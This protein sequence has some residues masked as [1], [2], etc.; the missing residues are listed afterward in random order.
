MTMT[1]GR[2]QTKVLLALSVFICV[3]IAA[4]S[5]AGISSAGF[6]AAEAPG[7]QVQCTGQDLIN[8]FFIVPFFL[9][10]AILLYYG[11]KK[12]LLPWTGCLLYL[13]YTYLVYCFDVHFNEFFIDYCIILGLSFYLCIYSFLHFI[14]SNDEA[15]FGKAPYRLTGVF[16]ITV[17]IAFVFLWLSEIIPAQLQNTLPATLQEA[18]LFTNPVHVIDLSV[19]LPG[20][21]IAG[22][23]LLKRNRFSAVI[24]PVLLTFF[25]LMDITIAVL[26]FLMAQKSPESSIPVVISMILLALFSLVL[27]IFHLKARPLSQ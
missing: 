16:F 20:V 13:I 10:S 5:Y 14:K 19:F 3:L 9:V 21:F 12:S 2:K 8:L 24:A 4:G 15:V 23:L 7:W 18:G 22:L 27:L 17:A 6:Y 1:M 25:I 11:R 26:S